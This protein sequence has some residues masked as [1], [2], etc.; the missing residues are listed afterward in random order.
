[1]K[2][3]RRLPRTAKIGLRARQLWSK[4]LLEVEPKARQIL[5]ISAQ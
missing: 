1:M 4:N 5:Q 3:F 2:V